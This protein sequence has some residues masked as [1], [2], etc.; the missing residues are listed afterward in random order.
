MKKDYE[1]INKNY[2]CVVIKDISSNN[3]LLEVS[4]EFEYETLKI[5]D[6]HYR[7][8]MDLKDTLARWTGKPEQYVSEVS[9]KNA[10]KMIKDNLKKLKSDLI[11]AKNHPAYNAMNEKFEK[12]VKHYHAD[13]T[14]HDL[15]QLANHDY[16]D[17]FIW[18]VRTCGTH[19][20]FGQDNWSRAVFKSQINS[21]ELS[22]CYY[23]NGT[24]LKNI[25]LDDGSNLLKHKV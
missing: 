17:H 12:I 4:I 18:I 3:Q 15:N 13:F 11:N 7:I 21:S 16:N 14:F 19:L 23:W 9:L 2:D 20:F 6:I 10:K 25:T 24:K 1:L 8:M 5:K 22:E